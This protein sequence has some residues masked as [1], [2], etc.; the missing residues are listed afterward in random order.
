[1]AASD[2][3]AAVRPAM[4][5]LWRWPWPSARSFAV[6]RRNFLVWRKTAL[7]TIL[8]DVLDPM[9]ALLALGYGLG[10]MLPG[11]EGVPY[12]T[13]LSAGS[14]CVGAL[15]GATFEA[16]YSAFSRLQIQ[17]T[18]DAMLNT[19]LSLDDVV[20]AEILWA[21][22]KAMKSG[23]AILLVVI[24]LDISRAGTLAW[25]PLVLL[26]MGVLFAAMSMIVSALARGYDFFMYYFTLVI[27]PMVFLS[28]VFFPVS[29]LPA[30]LVAVMR[31]LP[32]SPAVD[33][34][35]PLVLGHYPPTLWADLIQLI[36][37]GVA[38]VWGAAVLMRRRLLR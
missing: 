13:Y 17:R 37:T 38:A 21:A 5:G 28:G 9:V 26:P 36:V 22:A 2:N 11:V 29:Q 8:G 27:T 12:V 6:I 34:L 10:G 1:M 32:L 20:W 33:I 7:T 3:A 25:I 23:I 18:W 15:Y 30:P 16:T 19:P 24:A 4:P 31:W 14:I 35:R